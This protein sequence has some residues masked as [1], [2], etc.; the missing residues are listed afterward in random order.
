MFADGKAGAA[1]KADL[2][3]NFYRLFSLALFQGRNVA[4]FYTKSAAV[5]ALF[6]YFDQERRFADSFEIAGLNAGHQFA[7]AGAAVANKGRFEADIVCDVGQSQFPSLI[8]HGKQFVDAPLL[9]KSAP[10]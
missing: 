6:I 2:F 4:C 8:Q 3:S 7:A 9:G 1:A 5:A 10:D